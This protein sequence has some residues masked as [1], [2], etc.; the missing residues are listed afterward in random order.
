MTRLQRAPEVSALA[1]L[2]LAAAALLSLSVLF[3]MSDQ[4]PTRLG[5]AMCVVA[6]VLA[7]ATY[8]VGPRLPRRA[9]LGVATLATLLNT[10]LVPFAHTSAGAVADAV[11]YVWLVGYVALFFPHAATALAALVTAGYGAALLASGLPGMLAAW[12]L[13]SGT[14]W[15]V[16]VTLSRVSR[17]ARRQMQTD[18]LTGA[19]NRTGLAAA[20]ERIFAR[21]RRHKEALALVALDLDAFKKVNDM[22]G[23]A[24]GDRVLAEAAEAW[25]DALRGDDVLAR[26]GGDE[27]VL[28][29]P[30]TSTE[31]AAAVLERLRT[32][33]PVEWSAGMTQWEPGETLEECLLRAD[34]RLYE[35]K[36]I[37]R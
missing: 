35:A 25:S 30:G 27:F 26:V 28:L 17:A 31:E 15:A 9:L 22:G 16:A 3:P 20:A 6:L 2:L 8:A 23:H 19:L 18:L 36:P 29:L 11:A 10:C 7:T 24:A 33:H 34:H 1:A 5:A 14:I 12:L 21:T 13:M 37:A 4:A 32:A